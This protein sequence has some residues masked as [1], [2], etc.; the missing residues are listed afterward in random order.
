MKIIC[1]LLMLLITVSC[2]NQKVMLFYYNGLD[3]NKNS[4]WGSSLQIFFEKDNDIKVIPIKDEVLKSDL[5]I[6]KKKIIST[7]N[8]I[9]PDDGNYMFAFIS[10]K[11]TLFADNRLEFWRYRNRGVWFNLN[12]ATKKT[13]LS[14]YKVNPNQQ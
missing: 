10:K 1:F 7:N 13:I 9:I 5:L 12:D 6:I 8:I 4:T 3:L 14:Y 11:D 2:D